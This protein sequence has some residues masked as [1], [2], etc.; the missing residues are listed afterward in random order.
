[1]VPLRHSSSKARGKDDM[2]WG[3]QRIQDFHDA[4]GLA[5]LG[6]EPWRYHFIHV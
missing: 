3:L 2:I 5:G 4:A 6:K 1:M